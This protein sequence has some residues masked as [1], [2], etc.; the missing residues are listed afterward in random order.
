MRQLLLL[1]LL[2]P[3]LCSPVRGESASLVS[4]LN[5]SLSSLR[6]SPRF[7]TLPPASRGLAL[8]K[9]LEHQGVHVPQDV[10]MSEP[11]LRKLADEI[12]EKISPEAQSDF[13]AIVQK[14]VHTSSLR[15][16]TA[17]RPQRRSYVLGPRDVLAVSIFTQDRGSQNDDNTLSV[18]IN[19]QGFISLPLVG[20]VK[21]AG[22]TTSQVEEKVSS[23]YKRFVKDPQVS[24]SVA[25]HRARRVF[26]VGQVNENGPVYLRHE[27][28]TLFEIIS[29]VGGF[30][31]AP[32]DQLHGADA[33]NVI[34]QRGGEKIVVDFY[35]EATDTNTALDF[36]VRDGDQIFVPKP[37][38]RIR[39]LGGVQSSG[40]FELRPGMTLMDAIAMAGSFT[41]KS[42]RDQ[43]RILSEGGGRKKTR[44]L[45]AT[46]IFHGKVPDVPLSPGDVIYV[47][48][49]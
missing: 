25:E 11:D 19:E 24:V 20:K 7:E 47:S 33:R 5:S 44:Y 41:E 4:L 10:D 32:E 12:L 40:E 39:V 30:V 18:P 38:N 16:T 8:R 37:L 45:D 27:G 35:G 6:R 48:E 2:A 22:T 21:A 23:M 15:Q 3:L 14:A 13:R 34:V 26:V 17:N 1:G 42:R 36:E 43:I 28:T 49:W 46:R 31:N 29:R 9:V